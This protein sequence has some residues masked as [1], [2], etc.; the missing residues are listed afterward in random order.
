[1]TED[2]ARRIARLLEV[3]GLRGEAGPTGGGRWGIVRDGED[4]TLA[5]LDE[6]IDCAEGKKSRPYRGF[7]LPEHGRG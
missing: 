1:M 3:F 6:L 5:A 2:E 4:I 7:V